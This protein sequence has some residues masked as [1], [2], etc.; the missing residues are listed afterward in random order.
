MD[1]QLASW[2]Y[3]T[4]IRRIVPWVLDSPDAV[5]Y[6]LACLACLLGSIAFLAVACELLASIVISRASS[7]CWLNCLASSRRAIIRIMEA[8]QTQ[9][10]NREDRGRNRRLESADYKALV[11]YCITCQCGS[12]LLYHRCQ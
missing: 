7:S 4:G 5:A 2:K 1:I 8:P 12:P 11:A 6:W 3:T 9:S 10:Q